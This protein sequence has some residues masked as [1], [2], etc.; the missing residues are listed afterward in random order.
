MILE[1]NRI[2]LSYSSV[3]AFILLQENIFAKSSVDVW[4]DDSCWM[5]C[6]IYKWT[7]TTS[8]YRYRK[9][10]WHRSWVSWDWDPSPS[11]WKGKSSMD[12]RPIS[13]NRRTAFWAES[14]C[15]CDGLHDDVLMTTFRCT[16]RSARKSRPWTRTGWR[17]L[18]TI[19]TTQ[20]L[21]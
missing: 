10:T 19:S 18:K 15:T 17:M 14:F 3:H 7:Y 1:S 11:K 9:W 13:S 16:S 6:E 2:C 20:S 12:P 8:S 4:L 21:N 5:R